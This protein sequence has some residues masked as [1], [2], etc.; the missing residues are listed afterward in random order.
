MKLYF[1]YEWYLVDLLGG[2][3]GSKWSLV[4]NNQYCPRER[5]QSILRTYRTEIPVLVFYNT[6]IIWG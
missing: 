4:T 2:L 3:I 5:S 6:N 1:T